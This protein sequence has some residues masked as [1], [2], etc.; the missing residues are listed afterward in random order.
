MLLA[1][2]TGCQTAFDL[3]A[4]GTAMT[5]TG[6]MTEVPASTEQDSQLDRDGYYTSPDKVALFIHTFQR[7]PDNYMTKDEAYDLGWDPSRGN[8]WAVADRMSI[9]GDRFG[10][11][12]GLLPDR[13][14]RIWFECDV[15]YAGGMRGPER[16]VYSNDGL[17]YYTTDHY[18]SFTRLY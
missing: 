5:E 4:T 15:N 13:D 2:I 14:G 16:L 1:G 6:Q 8:L 3:T 11:F 18:R 10:N 9:G 12:E 17:V 7:L